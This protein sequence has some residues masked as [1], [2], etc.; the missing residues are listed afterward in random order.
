MEE[1]E[2]WSE[3]RYWTEALDHFTKLRDGGARR[4]T[5]DLREIEKVIY[6]GDGPAYKLM[7][8]MVSVKEKEGWDGYRGAPRLVLALLVRLNELAAHRTRPSHR[9]RRLLASKRKRPL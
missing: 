6:D 8:A 1:L 7:D 5:L 9:T 2:H 4:L 3:S